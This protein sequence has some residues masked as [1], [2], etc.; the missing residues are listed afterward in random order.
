MTP[1]AL[2]AMRAACGW[3]MRDTAT[4][5]D[6]ALATVLA[7]EQGKAVSPVTLRRLRRAFRQQGVRLTMRGEVSTIRLAPPPPAEKFALGLDEL[8]YVTIRRRK[9][10]T[11]RVLFEVPARLR[12]EGWPAVRPL[13]FSLARRGRLS[14]PR[15]VA[16]IRADAAV[17]KRRLDATRATTSTT[18]Q[19]V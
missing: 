8:P 10:G 3:S 4:A 14:D 16:A 18:G 7:A 1:A 9:D 12:P 6:L 19:E 5:A 2:R 15:E 13:P 17:L 11:A